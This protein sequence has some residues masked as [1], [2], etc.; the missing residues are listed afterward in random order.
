MIIKI[1]VATI[2]DTKTH[3][4]GKRLLII[5]DESIGAQLVRKKSEKPNNKVISKNLHK[6]FC[7]FFSID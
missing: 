3:K 5:S 1:I 2:C 6:N 4:F 7:I